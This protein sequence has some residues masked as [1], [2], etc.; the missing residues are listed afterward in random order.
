MT[1]EEHLADVE[2]RKVAATRQVLLVQIEMSEVKAAFKRG[3]RLP[4][5]EYQRLCERR[6]AVARR[7]LDAQMAAS[8]INREVTAARVAVNKEGHIKWLA[9]QNRAYVSEF[10][11]AN[12]LSEP[13]MLLRRACGKLE[14]LLS[15]NGLQEGDRELVGAIKDYLR[16]HGI[17]V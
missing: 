12:Q 13:Q 4:K 16:R 11:L 14:R 10:D 3:A 17:A 6:A 9:E 7:L 1:A 8:K 5:A 2:E 15:M